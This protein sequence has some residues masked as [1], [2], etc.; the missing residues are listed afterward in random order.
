[1]FLS[2]L[3][4]IAAFIGGAFLP[5]AILSGHA[6]IWIIAY[7]TML[8][9]L[10]RLNVGSRSGLC[11]IAFPLLLAMPFVAAYFAVSP[12]L[13]YL[14]AGEGID[15][16]LHLYDVLLSRLLSMTQETE[17]DFTKRAL[18][19]LIATSTIL[20]PFVAVIAGRQILTA[21]SQNLS[22]PAYMK[23]VWYSSALPRILG[24][25]IVIG[26]FVMLGM[27]N[28][29]IAPDALGPLDRIVQ[30]PQPAPVIIAAV[31]AWTT[32]AIL[33]GAL[34]FWGVT[35]SSRSFFNSIR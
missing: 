6:V 22:E 3:L 4:L 25:T 19:V 8:S 9:W 13:P 23:F 17:W 11:A 30:T 18:A 33:M 2:V 27:V 10:L 15:A 21:F 16:K 35:R 24:V 26:H 29:F 14:P 34:A 31:S 1:M 12:A 20:F 28:G 7:S 32:A 5:I